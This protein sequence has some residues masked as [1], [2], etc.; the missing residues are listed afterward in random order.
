MSDANA[1]KVP[2]PSTVYPMP[3]G[4]VVAYAGNTDAQARTA[5]ASAGW[6]VCD[7]S[8][9]SREAYRDLFICI[10]SIHG[11]GDGSTTFNLPD[12]RG[13]FLRGLDDGTGRDP[14]ARDRSA[15]AAG[16]QSG[17]AV[18][19]VQADAFRAHQHDVI[20]MIGDNNIDGVDSTTRYS[21]EH[22]NEPRSSSMTGG[23]ETRPINAAVQWLILAG[24]PAT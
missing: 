14:D 18:G 16:G 23:H 15:S 6:L 3:L 11:T 2:P 13:R 4:M 10:G 12:Y 19:S 24:N 21:G 9:V 5:L 17:D 7:G 20:E 1:M 8:A 22:H